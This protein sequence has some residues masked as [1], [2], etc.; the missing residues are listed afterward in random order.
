MLIRRVWGAWDR[1]MSCSPP[2]KIDGKC[3][4]YIRFFN[5]LPSDM[6]CCKMHQE[7]RGSYIRGWG[8]PAHLVIVWFF[9]A[10]LPTEDVDL[11]FLQPQLR[12]N[13]EMAAGTIGS[14]D[15]HFSLWTNTYMTIITEWLSPHSGRQPAILD[16]MKKVRSNIA[17]VDM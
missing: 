1:T 7:R 8:W 11:I 10:S 5:L 14:T 13:P 6:K 16:Y 15:Y 3:K 4:I 9:L 17:T 2:S 12:V